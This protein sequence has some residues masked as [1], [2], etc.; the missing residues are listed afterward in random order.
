MRSQPSLR[1]LRLSDNCLPV[2]TLHR[3]I[4]SQPPV[5]GVN[6]E[7][8]KGDVEL[9]DEDIDAG[10]WGDPDLDLDPHADGEANGEAEDYEPGEGDGEEGDDE[11]GWEMEVH[12]NPICQVAARL[13][14]DLPA[15]AKGAWGASVRPSVGAPNCCRVMHSPLHQDLESSS[16][17]FFPGVWQS[18]G[19]SWGVRGMLGCAAGPGAAAGGD[20]AADGGHRVGCVC[21]ANTWSACVTALAAE[22]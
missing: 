1:N 11:G 15:W 14:V 21:R 13:W 7:A 16:E 10:A 19:Q 9:E 3:A 17:I 8:S 12:V 18:P 5:F 4:C 6:A 2:A 22:G 20:A